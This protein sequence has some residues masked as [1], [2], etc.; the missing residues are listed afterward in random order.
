MKPDANPI[1]Q[2]LAADKGQ[3]A[4]YL[5]CGEYSSAFITST[6][7]FKAFFAELQAA[8]TQGLHL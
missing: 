8:D 4:E 6:D 5:E 2:K 1:R 7:S 3:G